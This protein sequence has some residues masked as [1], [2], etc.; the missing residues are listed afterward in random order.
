MDIKQSLLTFASSFTAIFAIVDPLAVIPVFLSLTDTYSQ[1]EREIASRKA[2]VIATLILLTFALSGEGIF[3]LFG[4]SMNAFRIAGGILLLLLGI[5]QLDAHRERVK[6]EEENESFSREDISIFPLAV[7][8][9]AG[10]GAIST[11]V[12]QSGEVK[13][14]LG[15]ALF[16]SAIMLAF[17]ASFFLLRS[18]PYLYRVL[19]KTGINLVTRV[20]GIILTAIAI[21]FIIDGIV[22]VIQNLKSTG[23]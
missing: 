9:L 7:P 2:C 1:K 14:F 16:I 22:G 6:T 11:V 18:A 19:G 17:V 23:S 10:P 15:M 4:I 21:Q 20:M 12:L 8:L 5:A 13:G 3:K